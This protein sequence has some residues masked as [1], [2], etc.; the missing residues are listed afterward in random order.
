MGCAVAIA[1]EHYLDIT[2]SP[3]GACRAYS[4]VQQPGVIETVGKAVPA[5]FLFLSYMEPRYHVSKG[6]TREGETGKRDY[7]HHLRAGCV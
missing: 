4:Y 6:K 3:R 2:T 1:S 5:I 7:R